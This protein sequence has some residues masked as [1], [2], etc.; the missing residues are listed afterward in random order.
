MPNQA[1]WVTHPWVAEAQTG[2]HFGIGYGPQIEG[3]DWPTLID[4]V[5]TADDLGFDSYW[6]S[7]HPLSWS[8]CWATLMPLA[9]R[10]RT[11]RCTVRSE[12]QPLPTR[13]EPG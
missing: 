6:T 2:V 5:Q 3:A 11:W 4:Y 7:D 10:T 8:D 13:S 9:A 1:T 12:L